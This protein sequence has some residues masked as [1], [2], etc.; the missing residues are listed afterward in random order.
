LQ[1]VLSH[2]LRVVIRKVFLEVKAKLAHSFVSTPAALSVF[3]DLQHLV[4][5]E[6]YDVKHV[7]D[8]VV[9]CNVDPL[10]ERPV[11]LFL[12]LE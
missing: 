6:G 2:K 11:V 4:I 1:D 8:M 7:D 9:T 10:I 5:F 3:C 12:S